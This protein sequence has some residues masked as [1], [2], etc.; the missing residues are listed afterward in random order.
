MSIDRRVPAGIYR[1]FSYAQLLAEEQRC[2]A[3]RQQSFSNLNGANVNGQSF[4]FGTRIDGTLAEW[5]DALYDALAY[6]APDK[7]Q[8]SG[9]N[10]AQI[11]LY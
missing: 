9:G 7:Y 2:I 5:V 1:G 4:Q 8:S 3:A 10:R 11:R 6:F